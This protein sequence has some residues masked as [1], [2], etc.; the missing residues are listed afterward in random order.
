MSIEDDIKTL[1]ESLGVAY[2]GGLLIDGAGALKRIIAELK[3]L[4]EE[5]DELRDR[6]VEYGEARD[7][8]DDW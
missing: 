7:M 8:R 4:R 3:R 2:A 5:V 1:E 6:A